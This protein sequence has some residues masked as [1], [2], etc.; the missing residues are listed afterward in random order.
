V[1]YLDNPVTDGDYERFVTNVAELEL[2]SALRKELF[3]L[4]LAHGDVLL[5]RENG[6]EYGL[7][8]AS[9]LRSPLH[10]RLLV[11]LRIS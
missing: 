8:Q 6:D 2:S 10:T 7:R 5:A 3:R 1:S 4:R 9:R 11:A